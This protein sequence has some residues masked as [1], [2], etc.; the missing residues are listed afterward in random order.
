VR[1]DLLAA[2]GSDPVP[3]VHWPHDL[4]RVPPFVRL[5]PVR[6]SGAILMAFVAL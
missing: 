5:F 3:E 4:E 6:A 2:A 1:L